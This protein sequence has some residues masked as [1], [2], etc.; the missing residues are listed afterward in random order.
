[1]RMRRDDEPYMP[2]DHA[3]QEP[4]ETSPTVLAL[5]AWDTGALQQQYRHSCVNSRGEFAGTLRWAGNGDLALL[6]R[7]ASLRQWTVYRL[8]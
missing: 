2:G 7:S 4:G 6:A 1:M 5:V 3:P 8:T